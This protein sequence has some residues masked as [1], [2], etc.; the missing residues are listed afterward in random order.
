MIPLLKI[1]LKK[2]YEDFKTSKKLELPAPYDNPAGRINFIHHALTIF[3]KIGLKSR[4]G[5]TI[6]MI[7]TLSGLPPEGLD[8]DGTVISFEDLRALILLIAEVP[9]S[10]LTGSMTKNPKYASLT[11]LFMYA[12]K[13]YD[14]V[15]YS[16]WDPKDSAMR[17]ALGTTL[18]KALEFQ[19][20]HPTLVPIPANVR[21]S[22]Y[23]DK[24]YSAYPGTYFK[25]SYTE[26]SGDV[27]NYP[28]EWL[29]LNCQYW[30]ASAGIRDTNSMLLDIKNFGNIPKAMDAEVIPE[31]MTPSNATW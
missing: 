6:S 5:K 25:Y 18:F 17:V 4:D 1:E 12:H 26:D 22:L 23:A 28:K 19:N 20:A 14:N 11:P 13:L 9:R 24:V 3:S 31:V 7:A 27:I 16:S 21:K 2:L 8:V 30:I 10:R 29:I 15:S